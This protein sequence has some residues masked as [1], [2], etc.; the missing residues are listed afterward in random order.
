M[1]FFLII[2][3]VRRGMVIKSILSECNLHRAGTG[4]NCDGKTPLGMPGGIRHVPNWHKPVESQCENNNPC[5]TSAPSGIVRY[6][7]KQHAD[8]KSNAAFLLSL[9]FLYGQLYSN[10]LYRE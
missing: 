8:T 10:L 2:I 3:S 5:A 4:A 9:I 6:I 7:Y 1:V